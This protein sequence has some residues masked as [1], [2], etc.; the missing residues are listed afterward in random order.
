M[1]IIQLVIVIKTM[2]MAQF[3]KSFDVIFIFQV[4]FN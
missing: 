3:N 1:K 2:M 4:Y